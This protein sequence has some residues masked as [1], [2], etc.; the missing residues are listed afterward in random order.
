[1]TYARLSP[2]VRAAPVNGVAGVVVAPGGK[3]FSVMAFT[4]R[5]GRIAAIDSLSDPDWLRR[6]DLPAPGG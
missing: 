6:L 1:M 4:V 5:D 3:P 2:F